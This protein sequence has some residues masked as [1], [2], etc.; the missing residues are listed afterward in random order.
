MCVHVCDCIFNSTNQ[1]PFIIHVMDVIN[2]AIGLRRR[3][4]IT[5]FS[6][7]HVRLVWPNIYFSTLH[8]YTLD[9]LRPPAKNGSS[10]PIGV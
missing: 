6:G 1:F 3:L 5:H 7:V 8:H 2:F 4:L 10:L 9:P